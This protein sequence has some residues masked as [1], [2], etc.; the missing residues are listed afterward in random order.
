MNV[1]EICYIGGVIILI[2]LVWFLLSRYC[3]SLGYLIHVTVSTIFVIEFIALA[4]FSFLSQDT[5]T[6]LIWIKKIYTKAVRFII[7]EIWDWVDAEI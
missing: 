4:K 3:C 7:F 5:T 2:S 1:L 6:V